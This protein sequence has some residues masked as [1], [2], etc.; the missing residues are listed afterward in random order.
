[1]SI[2]SH[3]GIETHKSLHGAVQSMSVVPS[4]L[5]IGAVERGVSVGLGL[6]DT[7]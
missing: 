4:E 3:F 5:G 2:G 6:L 1:M 7:V